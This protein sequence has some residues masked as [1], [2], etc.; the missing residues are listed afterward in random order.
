MPAALIALAVAL[1]ACSSPTAELEE[2]NRI[3]QGNASPA[4]SPQVYDPAGGDVIP[5]PGSVRS[6][7]A[8]GDR[9]VAQVDDPPSLEIGR[10]D[11]TRWVEEDSVPL[12][13]GAG[14]ASAT[15]DGTV[16]VPHSDG[17]VLVS[18]TGQV[19]E[20]TGLGPVT[21]AALTTDGRLLTGTPQGEIVVRDA[22]GAE[23]RRIGG[24]TAVDRISVARDG[25]VTALSRPDTVIA[26]IDLESDNAGPLL[27]AGKGAGQLDEFGE[28]S[29]VASDTLGGTLLVY[30][31]SPVRLHQQFPVAAAP[32]AVAEDTSRGLVWVTSTGTNTV[33]AYDLGDGVG[34]QRAD[35]PTVRQPDSLA[36]TDSGTVVVGSADG[37]GLHL[38]RPTLTEPAS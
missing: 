36:V 24:L 16:V 10:I 30:S 18:A 33:Q 37:A 27:R 7:V 17:V 1:T 21:A 26:S 34:I 14:D 6:L 29:V 28:R 19:R 2:Q 32:W 13:P 38:I 15:D 5:V 35:I 22:D 4:E 8:V 25:S 23:Q 3:A 9:V 31:T 11:G 12:P 20:I